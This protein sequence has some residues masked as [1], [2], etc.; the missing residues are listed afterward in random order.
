MIV[1]LGLIICP[2]VAL[3]LYFTW[4]HTAPLHKGGTDAM[5]ILGFKCDDDRIHPLLLDRLVTSLELLK[6]YDYKK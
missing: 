1:L 4:I 3:L 2:I 5:I 6:T